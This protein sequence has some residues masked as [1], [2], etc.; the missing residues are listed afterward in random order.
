MPSQMTTDEYEFTSGKGKTPDTWSQK[1]LTD[2]IID[3]ANSF[4]TA[5]KKQKDVKCYVQVGEEKINWLTNFSLPA[6]R[7]LFR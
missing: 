1:N 3:V 2:F 7:G 4:L 5:L 6:I